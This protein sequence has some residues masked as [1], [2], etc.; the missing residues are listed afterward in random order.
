M[1]GDFDFYILAL[2][3]SPTYCLSDDDPDPAQCSLAPS[4]FLVH[5]LWPQY[6]SGYPE[7]CTSSE[8][9]GIDDDT[10]NAIADV[11]P[12]AGLAHYQWRKHGM[13]SGLDADAYFSLLLGAA[14]E[15]AIP[16][17]LID[18]V[19]DL[20]LAPEAIEAAFAEA[21][22]GLRREGMSVQ[23]RQGRLTEVRIC[24]T[25]DLR[26]RECYEVDDDTCR[27]RTITVPNA[28]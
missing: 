20:R 4:G 1:A 23:C 24:L 6:E 14:D 27:S 10:L 2:S 17:D 26:F 7:Y 21:N 19:R 13:C 25:K 15:V 22:P 5:G 16:P 12:S 9:R 18:L 8:P 3:W 28:E 11:M